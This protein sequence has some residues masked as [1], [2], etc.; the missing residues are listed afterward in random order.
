MYNFLSKNGQLIAF[1]VG[2]I[3]VAAFWITALTGISGFSGTPTEEDLFGSNIFDIGLVG[4]RIL[5]IIAFILMLIFIVRSVIMNPKA[6][7]PLIIAAIA[8][9]VL[10]FIF[11]GMD[12]GTVTR[13]MEKYNV[14]ASEGGI[15][16]GGLWVAIIMFFGAWI[17]LI[18][19]ELRGIFR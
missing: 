12:A 11:R 15:V 16:S 4:A 1:I 10:F 18:L 3:V 6:S 14:S 17:V 13:S 9:V 2:V 5:A 8:I 19:S 7:M